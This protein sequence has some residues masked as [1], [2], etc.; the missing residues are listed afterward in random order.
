MNKY[1]EK[2]ASDIELAKMYEKDENHDVGKYEKALK[3]AKDPKLVAALKFALPEEKQHRA[4]FE[5]AVKH[6]ED[7]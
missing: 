3:T 7:K 2:I 4:K 1:L 6:I 5:T